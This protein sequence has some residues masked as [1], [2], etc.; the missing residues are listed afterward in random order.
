MILHILSGSPFASNQFTQVLA[1][2][3]NNDAVILTQ[4]SVYALR[5]LADEFYMLHKQKRLYVLREDAEA[6]AI[7]SDFFTYLDYSGFVDLC[8]KYKSTLSW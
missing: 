4:D 1:L 2:L 8:L 3:G 6:R 7:Q 5:D